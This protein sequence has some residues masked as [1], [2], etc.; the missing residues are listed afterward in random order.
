MKLLVTGFEPFG[1]EKINPAWLAVE[2]LPEKIGK[3][4]IHKLLVPTV[5]CR[6]AENA[7]RAARALSA[8]AVLSVGLAQGRKD[9]TPEMAALNL[10]YARI[11]D[12][13]GQTPMDTPIVPGGPAAYF[14]TLPVRRMAQAVKDRGLNASVSYSAGVYVCNDL[15]YSL[16]HHF[17]G[18][19][20]RA[21][22][23]HVP[24][25]P[26]MGEPSM[27]LDQIVSALIAAIEAIE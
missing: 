2:K 12:N 6:A 26:E 11:P 5:F 9:V 14:S 1:G 13:E 15:L 19:N 21:G 7:I 25:L 18:T 23:I 24:K 17:S 22:F 16:L 10:R 27:P 4:E 3:F 8:D 20:V